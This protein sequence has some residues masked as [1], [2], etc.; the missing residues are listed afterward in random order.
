MGLFSSKRKVV[1]G[2]SVSRVIEDDLL[3]DA[4][5]SGTIK[6]IL[7]SNDIHE[8]VLE[9][10]VSSAAIRAERMYD[11]ADRYSPH[12]LPTG[13]FF[14]AD[15]G[16]ALIQQILDTAEG[17]EVFIE[18]S[19]FGAP[20]NLHLGWTLLVADYGYNPSTNELTVLSAQRGRPVFL[21]DLRVGVPRQ[22]L[23]SYEQGSLV[24]WGT[25]PLAGPTPERP[26]V[27]G[28]VG[29]LR[30]FSP[31]LLD[32]VATDDFI[33]IQAVW[34]TASQTIS[35]QTIRVNVTEQMVQ[36][37]SDYFHVKY[38]V[39]GQTKFWM[40][41]MGAGTYPQ[42]DDLYGEV[43]QENGNFFP[44]LYF[45]YDRQS[46]IDNQ[47][48]ESYRRSKRM[49]KYLG[50]DYDRVAE[51]INEN[52]D[53]AD[54]TQ[55]MITFAVPANTEDPI[56][57]RYLFEFFD[58]LYSSNTNQNLTPPVGFT[59]FADYIRRSNTGYQVGL[60]IQDRRFKMVLGY[61]EILRS[62]V[63]GNIGPV[64][65]YTSGQ[66]TEQQEVENYDLETNT[67]TTSLVPLRYHYY[68]Y[69]ARPGLY[70]EVAI[71]GL[72]VLY[73]I[74]GSHK[75]IA[76]E[77]DDILLIPLDRSLVS[78]YSMKDRENLYSRAM[79]YVF[80]SMQVIKVRWY[81]TGIFRTLM[82]IIAIVMAVYDG[83]ATLGAYLGLQGA[84][85][86]IATIVINLAIGELIKLAFKLFAKVLG[87]ELAMLIAIVAL[88]VGSYQ[89]FTSGSLKGAPWASDL[90]TVANGLS[91]AALEIKFDDLLDD[92][93]NFLAFMEEQNKLLETAQ[94][95]LDNPVRLNPFVI[96]GESPTDYYN[97]TVHSGNIGVL[98]IDAVANYTEIAL[99]LPKF[100]DTLGEVL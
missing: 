40:Y 82:L 83:G 5:K 76:D 16:K 87:P 20:N 78:V 30:A 23:D 77:T 64:G 31:L 35:R 53:I 4:I 59:S 89:V 46:E 42:L 26:R 28:A 24:F 67:T 100:N 51:E 10:L 44:F 91:Q 11:Y 92:S 54:V 60:V 2:T 6:A 3:P 47:S 94:E 17:Q 56:E 97:R 68:R 65:T 43:P 14:G 36:S 8:D 99:T 55:A 1:V 50:L 73:Y 39:G 93:Q 96:F 63:A 75:V 79:H 62:R 13:E 15:T 98:V 32:P 45:R 80:N 86:I 81:Q 95:L 18:Y 9:S 21:H 61:R 72:R 27:N 70:E 57:R 38:T 41:R 74:E 66:A 84:A 29:A 85:A 71:V 52:P 90:L 58:R 33:E 34:R 37:E 25:S 49:A 48:T 88:L 12:G 19:N 22:M 7:R 69:Q